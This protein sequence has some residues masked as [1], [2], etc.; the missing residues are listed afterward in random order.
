MM[1]SKAILLVEDDDVDAKTVKRALRELSLTNP[2]VW[3]TNGEE[4]LAW[5]R[6]PANGHP[7]IIL[8]DLNMPVMSGIEFLQ[9]AKQDERLRRIPV[10][11]VTTSALE[12]DKLASF[13][14]SVAGYMIKPVDYAQFV[15]VVRAINL[16][17]TLSETP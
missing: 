8:L 17:W 11:V 4:A 13:D 2:L 9:V 10:V 5:L 12:A 7:G 6:D 14:L 15:E 1:P 3:V 16:Y